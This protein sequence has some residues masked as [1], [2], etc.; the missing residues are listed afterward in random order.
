MLA[1]GAAPPDVLVHRVFPYSPDAAAGE[2]GHPLYLHR[3]QRA[4]R[5]D[6][7]DYDAWYL[8][9][10]PEEAVGEVP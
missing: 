10:Q 5:I 4:G 6:S 2:P 7:P 8:S 1:C 9:R 3:P